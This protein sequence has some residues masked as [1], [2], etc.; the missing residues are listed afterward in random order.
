MTEKTNSTKTYYQ[1]DFSKEF[2]VE[3]GDLLV[4]MDGEFN[5]CVWSGGQA[6]LNQ[7]VC[8]LISNE[9]ILPK[10]LDHYSV[11]LAMNVLPTGRKTTNSKRNQANAQSNRFRKLAV[12]QDQIQQPNNRWKFIDKIYLRECV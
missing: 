8:K 3:N 12:Y 6:L 9:K 5:A 11:R 1:G 10:V 7:R 4:G 2:L